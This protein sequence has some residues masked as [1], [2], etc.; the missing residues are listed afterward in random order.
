MASSETIESSTDVVKE[1]KA[2]DMIEKE[3]QTLGDEVDN[4]LRSLRGTM[5]GIIDLT[6]E[7]ME[8]YHSC[9]SK[10][11]DQA[12]QAIKHTF[13][14]MA[15]SEELTKNLKKID[16]VYKQVKELREITDNVA[17]SLKC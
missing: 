13:S 12:E 6:T 15:K 1:I 8:L 10:T 17:R 5:R 14:V 4:C 9:I 3:R 7:G 16:E 2:M 11:C